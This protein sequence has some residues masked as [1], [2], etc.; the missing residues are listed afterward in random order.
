LLGILYAAL[1]AFTFALNNATM[2]RG[3]VTGSVLQG[4][5]LTVPIGGLSFLAMTIAFG[6]LGQLVVIP[7]AAIFWLACQGVVHFV[8]GRYCNYRANQLMGVNLAAPVIQL[9]VPFAMIM[10]VA[11]LHEA[12]TAL[13]AIGTALM[14]GG[15][16]TTQSNAGTG[17]KATA[18]LSAAVA[19]AIAPAQER[20]TEVQTNDR[21]TFQPQVFWGCIFALGAAAFYGASPLLAREAFLRAP[22]I[23][24]VAAGCVAYAAAMLVFSLALL[25]PGSWRDIRSIKPENLRWFLAAAVLVAISQALVYDSLAIAPLMVVTPI[26]QLSLVFRLFLSQLINRDHE[27]MNAAVLIGAFTAVLGSILVS[28]DTNELTAFLGLPASVADFL[29]YR[30][31]GG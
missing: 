18:P 26:L 1:G 28:L 16:F 4:M 6:E 25:K 23:S 13:Q 9:Q 10:A 24:T 31:A 30:L 11:A 2:R 21:P 15:S 8:M 19:T 7:A 20:P 14:L 27:V 12:F 29:S 17:R 3:V 22:G 5:A